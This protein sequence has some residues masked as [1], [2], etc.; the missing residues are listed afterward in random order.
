MITPIL[1]TN[2]TKQYN[3]NFKNT[4]QDTSILINFEKF[5]LVG[6]NSGNIYCVAYFLEYNFYENDAY[7]PRIHH[8]YQIDQGK[9]NTYH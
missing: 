5:W 3:F 7:T 8:H 2:F 9:S 6:D 1:G 4:V